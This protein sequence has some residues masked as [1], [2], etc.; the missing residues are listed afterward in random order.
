MTGGATSSVAVSTSEEL[1]MN[2][3]RIAGT[4]FAL[5]FSWGGGGGG[6]LARVAAEGGD[7]LIADFEGSDYGQWVAAGEAF[8]KGPAGGAIAGQ[9]AVGGFAGKGLVNSFFNGDGTQGT[10]TSPP[11]TVERRFVNFLIGGGHHP[12]ETCV[13]LIVDGKVV[14]TSTGRDNEQLDWETWDGGERKW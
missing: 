4:L 3:S 8:G 5:V 12:G 1:S 14:R 13:N 7:I 9:M 6:G 2:R 10:L 11:F